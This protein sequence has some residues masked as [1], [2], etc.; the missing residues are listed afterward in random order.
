MEKEG[1]SWMLFAPILVSV[2]VH[3]THV[4]LGN[5]SSGCIMA[6]QKKRDMQLCLL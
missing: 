1:S 6:G 4:K 2:I 3:N 5:G